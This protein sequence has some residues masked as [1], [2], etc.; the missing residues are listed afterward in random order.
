MELLEYK[1]RC[2]YNNK[3]IFN[4]IIIFKN[5]ISSYKV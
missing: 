2:V 5:I 1:I 4:K 3:Q